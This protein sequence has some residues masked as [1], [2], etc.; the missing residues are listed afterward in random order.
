[1]DEA[2]LGPTRGA[3]ISSGRE[4]I[5]FGKHPLFLMGQVHRPENKAKFLA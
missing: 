2:D 1:M 3:S 4:K 5:L